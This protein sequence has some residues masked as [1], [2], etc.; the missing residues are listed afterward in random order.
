MDFALILSMA[1]PMRLLMNSWSPEAMLVI[2]KMI[3]TVDW[4]LFRFKLQIKCKPF[5][6]LTYLLLF[7][8]WVRVDNVGL[9]YPAFE[10][11]LIDLLKNRSIL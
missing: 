3:K 6:K 11:L 7:C 5:S 10:S 1:L 8:V 2:L 9:F 4:G